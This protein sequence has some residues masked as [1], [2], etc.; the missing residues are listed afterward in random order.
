MNTTEL[1]NSLR[2]LNG[3]LSQIQ[4]DSVNAIL[5]ACALYKVTS[6][7]HISYILATAY[8]ESRFKPVREIGLG[9]GRP[10][11]VADQIT[12]QT[13]YGR[14]FVQLTWKSNYQ[15]FAKLL[16]LSLVENPDLAMQIDCA[17]EII[18]VG[19]KNGIFTG[20]KLSNYFTGVTNDP[21]NARRIVNG[22]DKAELIS[23]YYKTILAGITH[24]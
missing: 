9:H 3:S 2:K 19:M 16:N 7:M 17:A 15:T 4:V 23:G 6:D 5:E 20:K 10:Y 1:F 18:V 24:V 11:G 8:H 21:V 13:Y 14:G 12:H 22:S